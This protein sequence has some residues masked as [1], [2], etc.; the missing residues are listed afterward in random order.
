MKVTAPN[1]AA[2]GATIK[3]TSNTNGVSTKKGAPSAVTS[4]GDEAGTITHGHSF[5]SVLDGVTRAH[6]RREPSS[7]ER[8]DDAAG[9]DP[10]AAAKLK[11]GDGEREAQEFEDTSEETNYKGHGVERGVVPEAHVNRELSNATP[12]VRAILHIA[13]LER[14]VAA[15]RTQV[16]AGGKREVTLELSRSVLEGL[17]IKL[18]TNEAGRIDAEFIAASERVRTQIDARVGDLSNLL[19]SRGISLET[20]KT[21]VG[22]DSSSQEGTGENG[23][24]SLGRFAAESRRPPQVIPGQTLGIDS[25]DIP[26]DKDSTNRTLYRA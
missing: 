1:A 7:D 15:V 6:D 2:A 24:Q 3:Q 9:R 12:A 17:R 23:K 20:L 21:S 18:K 16:V 11:P 19:R 13:D 4:D 8:R 22:A 25:A 26:G 14:I 5:A 10:D